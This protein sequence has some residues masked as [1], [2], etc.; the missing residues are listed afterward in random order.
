M[1]ELH[2]GVWAVHGICSPSCDGEIFLVWTQG[3]MRCWLHQNGLGT[4]SSS[5]PRPW[6]LP[7]WRFVVWWCLVAFRCLCIVGFLFSGLPVSSFSFFRLT[8]IWVYSMCR[9]G[10]RRSWKS[11]CPL[12]HLWS[13][14]RGIGPIWRVSKLVTWCDVGG[15]HG[16][17]GCLMTK[18]L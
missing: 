13:V 10:C 2:I 12:Q 18:F 9:L 7:S 1:Q 16:V 3:T 15:Q 6:I 4:L 14:S 5:L 11:S 8:S 17:V